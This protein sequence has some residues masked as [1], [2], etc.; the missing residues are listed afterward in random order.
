[1][2]GCGS[3]SIPPRGRRGSR[4][5]SRPGGCCSTPLL[6]PEPSA[7]GAPLADEAP[8]KSTHSILERSRAAR[9]ERLELIDFRPE[10]ADGHALVGVVVPSPFEG[11]P[12]W[13]VAILE[14]RPPPL[15]ND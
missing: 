1:M 8:R 4:R 5:S 11:A 15:R 2:T 9:T 7:E 14:L 6:P 10:P 13:I 12:G 3:R